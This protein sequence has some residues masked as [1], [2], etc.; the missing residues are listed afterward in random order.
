MKPNHT[1][2]AKLSLGKTSIVKLNDS[3]KQAIAGGEAGTKVPPINC[4]KITAT[5]IV[6][7]G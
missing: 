5:V 6:V 3:Q 1:K 7:I 2:S 4:N